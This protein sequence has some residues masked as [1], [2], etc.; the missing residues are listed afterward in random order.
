MNEKKQ[1]K[2]ND[3]Y[4]NI[5]NKIEKLIQTLKGINIKNNNLNIQKR[6]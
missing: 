4:N 1:K 2:L 5:K 6:W 3:I